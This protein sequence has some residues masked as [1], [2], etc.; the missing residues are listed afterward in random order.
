M[1]LMFDMHRELNTTLVLV[2]HDMRLAR[3][4]STILRLEGGV[5]TKEGKLS[6][7]IG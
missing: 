5:M 7:K 1:A 6:D 2:T 4:C 3:R